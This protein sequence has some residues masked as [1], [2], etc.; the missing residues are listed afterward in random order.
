[1]KASRRGLYIDLIIMNYGRA[2]KDGQLSLVCTELEFN[3]PHRPT[4][5]HNANGSGILQDVPLLIPKTNT[6]NATESSISPAGQLL[7]FQPT[8]GL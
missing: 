1:M 6:L 7:D 8:S 2:S 5:R 4:T 3:H